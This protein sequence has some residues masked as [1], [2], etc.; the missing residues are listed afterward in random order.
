MNTLRVVLACLV[1]LTRVA[2]A[3]E[4]RLDF[5]VG[6]VVDV[7]SESYGAGD[8]FFDRDDLPG[9]DDVVDEEEILRI[10]NDETLVGASLG[11]E[12]SQ[13]DGF[14]RRIQMEYE[15]NE[16]SATGDVDAR[17]RFGGDEGWRVDVD[18]QL[19]L[20]AG[21]AEGDE[22]RDVLQSLDVDLSRDV[23]SLGRLTLTG[24]QSFSRVSG[25]SLS[26]LFD[27]TF[28]SLGLRLD[29]ELGTLDA[30]FRVD[31]AYRDAASE[32][33]SNDVRVRGGA[34][35]HRYAF[36]GTSFDVSFLGTRRSYDDSG[37]VSP[38]SVEGLAEGR[39][40]HPLGSGFELVAE[41]DLT[42]V[43]FDDPDET[44]F[45]Y[46]VGAGELGVAWSSTGGLT[47]EASAGGE[48]LRPRERGTGAYDQ[49][50][51]RL[52]ASVLGPGKLWIDVEE[53][54]GVRDYLG[55]STTGGLLTDQGS[56]DFTSTDFAYSELSM[57]F[58][59][60]FGDVGIDAYAQYTVEAHEDAA[61][62]VAFVI[63]N[64]KV[65]SRF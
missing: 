42:E 38:S 37:V 11:I 57:L 63:V 15:Q 39:A 40:S 4:Y 54:F 33:S 12:L 16:A 2:V 44:Y 25:D 49:S 5:E 50:R 65:T 58:G 20:Q 34:E 31:A 48:W 41:G 55:T 22:S 62:D 59:Y 45:D 56:L 1:A 46:G 61:D 27:Y 60:A 17:W 23:R 64:V 43:R 8:L 36:E 35:L 26:R 6:V 30:R 9:M 3:E 29:R 47:L 32:F 13:G 53:S 19:R 14:H 24:E 51:V 52:G 28:H 21:L 7:F 18:E 10:E